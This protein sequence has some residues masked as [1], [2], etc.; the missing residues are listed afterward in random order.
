[1]PME[2][3]KR[4]A[5]LGGDTAL[6]KME[7]TAGAP[8]S[9]FS[10][11]V[12]WA[13]AAVFALVVLWQVKSPTGAPNYEADNLIVGCGLSGC[14]LAYL[15]ALKGE[16]SVIIEKRDHIAGN[17]YDY[18]DDNHI[19][20]SLYG[21]HF[22]HTK[23]EK[24]WTYLT[25]FSTWLPF[26]NRVLAAVGD[27]VAPVPV[28][29]DTVNILMNQKI[30]NE[31]EM[32]EWLEMTQIK[33]PDG[34][35]NAE[36]AAKA[37]VGDELYK[38]LFEGY[39]TKQ[40]DRSPTDLDASVTQRIPVRTN[41]DE[42]YFSDP[43]QAEP[44]WGF[45]GLIA[46]MID[47]PNIRYFLNTDF[48]EFRKV[49][50]LSKYKKVFYTGP[51]DQYFVA[52]GYETLE[53]RSLKFRADTVH[54]ASPGQFVQDSVQFNRPQ[55]DIPFTRTCEYTWIPWKPRP[56]ADSTASTII[57][58][59][60]STEGE[61]YYPLPNPRNHELFKKYQLL[62]DKEQKEK[63][64]YFI[65]RLANYKYFNMDQAALN[66]INFYERLYDTQLPV[67][68]QDLI[69]I[70]TTWAGKGMKPPAVTPLKGQFYTPRYETRLWSLCKLG[71]KI[72][73]DGGTYWVV[74]EDGEQPDSLVKDLI[75]NLGFQHY[76]YTATGPSEAHDGVAQ[77]K[78]AFDYIKEN[79]MDE[80]AGVWEVNDL[81]GLDASAFDQLR[82][83]DSLPE[84]HGKWQHDTDDN[85][86]GDLFC[87]ATLARL[88][89]PLPAGHELAAMYAAASPAAARAVGASSLLGLG[90]GA[91]LVAGFPQL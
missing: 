34:P 71:H 69:F 82:Q 23:V 30:K 33:Y 9:M 56:P 28:G 29:I 74:V 3:R 35:K 20:V 55:V 14:I 31:A 1:M 65:G 42:R 68:N 2:I 36:E 6:S 61:P 40:W 62:A 37:R 11:K 73:Q 63:G 49:H 32:K 46:N 27:K 81:D 13:A 59:Y 50:D 21:P 53:Y 17:M 67:I 86:D 60:P 91:G 89:V 77:T 79:K 80:N 85:R 88:H 5:L 7:A 87:A 57:Y 16:T 41:F 24:V 52:Q 10:N 15:H 44:E 83:K 64:V 38:M 75:F 26:E 66:A 4:G 72:K 43:H 39:T 54:A 84:A 18:V 48:F 76:L 90:L 78:A 19:R 12:A 51:I 45:T 8:V 58:E 25:Q 47:H 22:F 70:T